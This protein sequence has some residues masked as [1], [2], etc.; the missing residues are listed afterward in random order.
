MAGDWYITPNEKNALHVLPVI[1][2]NVQPLILSLVI[3]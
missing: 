2:K 1:K 3:R